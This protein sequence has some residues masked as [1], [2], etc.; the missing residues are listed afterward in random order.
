MDLQR[1]GNVCAADIPAAFRGS[2]GSV[3]MHFEAAAVI[4]V[5]VLLEQVL[6]LRARRDPRL[7]LPRSQD[8]PAHRCEWSG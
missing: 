5:L 7:A 4:T 8:R 1:A 6:E 2:D 3:A